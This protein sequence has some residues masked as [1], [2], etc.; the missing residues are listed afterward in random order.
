MIK[1][2]PAS[3]ATNVRAMADHYGADEFM[4]V[5]ITWDHDARARSYELLAAQLLG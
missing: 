1:G 2:N 3:V 5:T 4:A